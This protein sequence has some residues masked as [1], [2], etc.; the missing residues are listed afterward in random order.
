M[1]LTNYNKNLVSSQ[2][3]MREVNPKP[4]LNAMW[5]KENNRLICK[6]VVAA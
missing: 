6:W 5:V 4:R 1:L 3:C 2:L